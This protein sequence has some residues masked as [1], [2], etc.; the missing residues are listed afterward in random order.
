ME[1]LT[2]KSTPSFVDFDPTVIPF[3]ARLVH[4]IDFE[5]DWSIGV[6]EILCSGSVGSSKSLV[7]AH[8]AI[9][10]CLKYKNA[11][12]LIGRRSLPDL[13]DT[14]F[15]KIVEHLECSELKNG[16][17]YF[18]RDNTADIRFSNGSQI[19]SKSWA[20]KH[21]L[22][23]RSLELSAALIEEAVENK[24]DDYQAIKEIR[25]RV[26]R[27][28]HIKEKF[29]LYLTNPD[30]PAHP[31]YKD[32]F[33][34]AKANRHVYYSLTEQNPFLEKTYIQNL[35]RDMSAKEARRMLD[36]EW[37]EIDKDRIYYEYDPQFNYRK[38]DYV[39][40]NLL[41]IALSFDFNM[42]QGKP[43]SCSIDQYDYGTDSF[44]FFNEV[45]VFGARTLSLMEEISDRGLLDHPVKFEIFGDA[46]GQF[47]STKS[48]FS[49]Y[50]II[51]D[52]L[53][54]YRTKTNQPLRFEL[55]VPKGNPPIRDRHN[56]VNAYC[57]NAL[58]QRRLF[59]YEKA[60]TLHTGLKLVALAKGAQYLEDQTI[61]GQDITTA[62]GYR[63]IYKHNN[64]GMIKGGNIG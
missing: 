58:K 25:Q 10:H 28:P 3:Q 60:K 2:E 8:I 49:D 31:L 46:S 30:S 23:L 62:A 11:R 32:F 40:N 63:I 15:K 9:K 41:P 37:I 12:F 20:D 50:E 55:M 16:L 22:K 4:D 42:R 51:T 13:K 44:H 24:G 54:K 1:S 33:D 57:H 7:G 39:I 35:R 27:L 19:I 18:I 56:I 34:V 47:G 53:F 21:Y 59:V 17:D 43:M 26:G 45:S 64:K 36:G 5:M 48:K 52:F 61:E 6:H 38:T 14:I 29:I